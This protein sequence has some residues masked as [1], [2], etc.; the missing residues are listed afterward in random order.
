MLAL[1]CLPLPA[2]RAN[3]IH[4]PPQVFLP[5]PP[6]SASRNAEGS[7]E[8]HE[9]CFPH[10]AYFELC[11]R[12]G[13]RGRDV[14]DVGHGGES[15][16]PWIAPSRAASRAHPGSSQCR[17]DCTPGICTCTV[18]VTHLHQCV[19]A[20]FS[21]RGTHVHLFR[22]LHSGACL[23]HVLEL[24]CISVFVRAGRTSVGL[25]ACLRFGAS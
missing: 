6:L 4:G 10:P 17:S 19:H 25:C 3:I 12:L 11:Q 9:F 2:L 20:Y 21:C 14:A 15:R 5:V 8:C 7:G 18:R 23:I 16:G 24:D 22:P 1:S 13:L